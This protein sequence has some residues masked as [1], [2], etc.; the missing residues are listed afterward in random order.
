MPP[1]IFVSPELPSCFSPF[2]CLGAPLSA[3]LWRKPW[4]WHRLRPQLSVK[5]RRLCKSSELLAGPSSPTS[6]RLGPEAV[7][8]CPCVSVPGGGSLPFPMAE[9]LLVLG[10][11]NRKGHAF[12]LTLLPAPAPRTGVYK[13]V[14]LVLR[15]GVA[16]CCP[17]ICSYLSDPVRA[18]V[19][20]R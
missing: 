18:Q 19:G 15:T 5:P 13:G 4:G 10:M 6:C 14:F 8:P 12:P 3:P 9:T 1:S 20:T 7:I 2:T 16:S 17:L 11:N